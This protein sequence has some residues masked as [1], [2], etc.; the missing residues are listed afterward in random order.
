MKAQR[1][2]LVTTSFPIV[3]DGSEAAGAFVA[4]LAGEIAKHIEVSVVAPGKCAAREAWSQR[5]EIYRYA[6]PSRPLSTL[7]PWRPADLTWISRVLQEGA[8]VTRAAA[9]GATHLF[10]LWGLPCGEWARR[11]TRAS[12]IGYSVWMLGSDVW[13]LGRVPFLRGMLGR[14]I[15]QADHAYADGYRLAEDAKRIAGRPVMF[16]PSTRSI[17]VGDPA[18]I[19]EQ[20]PYTLLFLGRWHPNKGVDLLLDALSQLGDA[21]WSNI[22]HVE[23]Q[24]GGSLEPLVHARVAALQM[25]GRPVE[26]GRFLAKSDAEAA[27]ARADWV[28]IPSRIESIPIVFSD[29][30]KSG[31]PVIATPAGDLPRLVK[32]DPACGI[33][34]EAIS[35]PAIV[36]ALRAA[37][38]GD[39][40]RYLAGVR[41]RAEEFALPGVAQR[42]L[43]DFAHD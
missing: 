38:A 29:A 3:S 1:L 18:P 10:A 9:I 21:D 7:K 37:F 43:R 42:L 17:G 25:A 31:R 26:Q 24:G 22:E 20:P 5:I 11:A 16:L 23:I 27:I 8:A 15:R 4:D 39:A 35:A 19:R 40:T 33:L 34:A 28:V 12:D 14:V 41:E 13:S 6:A 36:A 30:I 2:V 32:G